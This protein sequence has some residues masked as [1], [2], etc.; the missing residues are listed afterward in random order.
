MSTRKWEAD[1]DDEM[2]KLKFAHTRIGEAV[3]YVVGNGNAWIK[4][5]TVVEDEFGDGR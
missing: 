3:I 5:D 1:K 4:S 2:G